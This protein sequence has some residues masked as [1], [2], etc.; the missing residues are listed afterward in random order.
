MRP[1]HKA[2]N[3]GQMKR[4]HTHRAGLQGNVQ[5]CVFQSPRH[6]S[7]GRCIQSDDLCVRC[8]FL[9]SFDQIMPAGDEPVIMN[10]DR[11]DGD[12]SAV[13]GFLRF[14]KGELHPFLVHLHNFTNTNQVSY[15]NRDNRKKHPHNNRRLHKNSHPDFE[16]RETF[17]PYM[18][19]GI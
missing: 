14:G 15:A 19:Q 6:L 18:K 2:R 12:L 10:N 11:T 16:S 5:C 17:R 8:W 1:E 3:P 9:Q 7:I 13:S 4:A